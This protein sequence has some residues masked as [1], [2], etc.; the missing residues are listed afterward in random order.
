[1]TK[2][3]RQPERKF[4]LPWIAFGVILLVAAG[5]I[6]ISQGAGGGGTPRLSVNPASIA[7]GDVKLDTNLNFKIE[8]SN[9][10]DGP[11]RFQEEPYI[12]VVEGC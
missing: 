6:F 11:L 12:E 1:M 10:G 5:I 8:V 2:N 7:Y 4:P 3:R 9:Q